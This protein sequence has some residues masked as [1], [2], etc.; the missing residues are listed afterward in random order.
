VYPICRVR[1]AGSTAFL[2]RRWAAGALIPATAR[3]SLELIKMTKQQA[4]K[5]E[6]NSATRNGDME[7]V[8]TMIESDEELRKSAVPTYG[9]LSILFGTPLA[10]FTE[11]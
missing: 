5:N 3:R 7:K 1:T 8:R 2:Q 6:L 10:S 4:T 9:T 11:S